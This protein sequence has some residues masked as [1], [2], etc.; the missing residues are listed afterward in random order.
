MLFKII[1]A[2]AAL[3]F[4][5]C[6]ESST[7]TYTPA[8]PPARPSQ[9]VEPSPEIPTAGIGSIKADMDCNG[10]T[11]TT[12]YTFGNV[13]QDQKSFVV[14]YNRNN[15][16]EDIAYP[17]TY[18]NGSMTTVNDIYYVRPNDTG[19][20][21]NWIVTITYQAPSETYDLVTTTI[22]QPACEEEPV[23]DENG[24]TM[25]RTEYRVY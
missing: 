19:Y 15:E 6:D 16:L 8:Q 12:K 13:P 17:S 20:P 7:P 3:T 25:L 14:Q 23:E 11:I 24:S 1:I 2:L 4:I 22:K 9:P 5:G 10:G 18:T 21:I